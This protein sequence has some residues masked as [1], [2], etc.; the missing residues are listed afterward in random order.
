MPTFPSWE[1]TVLEETYDHV[2]YISLHSYY[3]NRSDDLAGYLAKSIDMERFIRSVVAT[4]DYVKAKKRSNRTIDL[5]FDE[6][7][8]WFHSNE[9]DKEIEPW[10]VAPPLL[11]DIYTHE[12]ALLVGSLLL[13]LLRNADRVKIA[14]QAQLVNVIAPIMTVAGGPAWRQTIF[15]P[16][17]QAAAAARGVAMNAIVSSPQYETKEF[18]AVDQL[19]AAAVHNREDGSVTV[20]CVNRGRTELPLEVRLGGFGRPAGNGAVEHTSLAHDDPKATNGPEGETVRPRVLP[21]SRFEGGSATVAVPGLSW[22]VIRLVPEGA[23]AES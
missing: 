4:A 15:Y 8:V 11:E 7:N 6:W 21:A 12:D 17:A 23:R 22:N 20:L 13:T 19:D 3:G 16:F 14:C 18:G 10:S 2:E 1:A 9:Q 5:A